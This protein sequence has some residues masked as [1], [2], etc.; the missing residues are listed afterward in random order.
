ML[1]IRVEQQEKLN[2]VGFDDFQERARLHLLKCFPEVFSASG[3]E[4]VSRFVAE[5]IRSAR[6]YAITAE[7][8]VIRYLDVMC[9]VGRR[10]DTE[11][12][13]G[14]A[15]AILVHPDLTPRQKMDQLWVRTTEYLSGQA[16]SK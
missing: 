15:H 1:V 2:Q 4:D 7:H 3:V 10:F 12:C 13:V 9:L 6:K 14:L 11:P 16:R 8:D 5:G